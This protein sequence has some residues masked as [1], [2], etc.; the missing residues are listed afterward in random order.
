MYN[1]E[2]AR[3]FVS[4]IKKIPREVQE[5]F[6]NQ[7]LPFI[8]SDPRCGERFQGAELKNYRKIAFRIKRNDYRIVYQIEKQRICIVFIAIGSRENFYKKLKRRQLG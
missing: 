6:T 2:F 3:S 8:L 7:W 5:L 1:A 4:D